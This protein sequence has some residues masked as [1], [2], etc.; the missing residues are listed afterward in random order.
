M[1]AW[2]REMRSTRRE[3]GYDAVKMGSKMAAR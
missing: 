1:I 3:F 2:K